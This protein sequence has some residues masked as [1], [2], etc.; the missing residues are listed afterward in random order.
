MQNVLDK[1]T[2]N[3]LEQ[4]KKVIEIVSRY[5]YVVVTLDSD[6]RNDLGLDSMDEADLEKDLEFEF[7]FYL[8]WFD[9]DCFWHNHPKVKDLCDF[10][11]KAINEN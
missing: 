4:E 9:W 10:I 1:V 2:M 7:D 11:Q 3:R 6:I 5:T 8:E